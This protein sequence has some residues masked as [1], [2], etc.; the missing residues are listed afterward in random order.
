MNSNY[1]PLRCFLLWPVIP[2]STDL[3]LPLSSSFSLQQRPSKPTSTLNSFQ[4]LWFCFVLCMC[5]LGSTSYKSCM[6]V[7]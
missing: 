1:S 4:K 6:S 7:R 3:I 2:L 5:V